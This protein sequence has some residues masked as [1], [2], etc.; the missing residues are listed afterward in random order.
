VDRTASV[1]E[2][3]F[4]MGIVFTVALCLNIVVFFIEVVRKIYENYQ[5]SLKEE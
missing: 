3:A 5:A 2:P 4:I 1:A